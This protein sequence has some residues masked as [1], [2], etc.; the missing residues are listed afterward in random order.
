M[1]VVGI[2]DAVDILLAAG[3][4]PNKKNDAGLTP[5]DCAIQNA[6]YQK[7]KRL[8]AHGADRKGRHFLNWAVFSDDLEM[9]QKLLDEGEDIN[10]P[11][12]ANCT[13]LYDIFNQDYQISQETREKNARWLMAHGADV[14]RGNMSSWEGHA[15]SSLYAITA[16]Q[17]GV[18][19]RDRHSFQGLNLRSP[20]LADGF[21][22]TDPP[23]KP[24][25]F[26]T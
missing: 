8:I 23:G 3:Y 15:P 18:K 24:T 26:T 13:I 20:A 10:R 16:H 21:S 25:R 9:A 22:T 5:L 7:I 12:S 19:P 6:H 2:A 11:N 4:D 17:G 14:T 1:H